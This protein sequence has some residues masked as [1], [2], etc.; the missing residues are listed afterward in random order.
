MIYV[1]LVV[2]VLAVTYTW[3]KV[4]LFYY[5]GYKGR[6]VNVALLHIVLALLT[7]LAV[8]LHG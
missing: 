5:N 1:Y 6:R 7:W 3:T 2:V 4:D 8:W